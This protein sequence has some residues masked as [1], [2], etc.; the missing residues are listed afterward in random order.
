MRIE[1]ACPG[2][3]IREDKYALLARTEVIR[4]IHGPTDCVVHAEFPIVIDE[5]MIRVG[6]YIGLGQARLT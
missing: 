3:F 5:T 6:L 2:A 4:A 1:G